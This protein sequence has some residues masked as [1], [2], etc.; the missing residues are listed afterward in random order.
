V[1]LVD[2]RRLDLGATEIYSAAQRHA[3]GSSQSILPVYP[4][5]SQ[6]VLSR[7]PAAGT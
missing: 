5:D 4:L 7:G 6:R 2:D 3:G 1:I